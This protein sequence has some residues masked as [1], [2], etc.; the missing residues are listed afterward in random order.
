MQEEFNQ[1]DID[2]IKSKI[3][4]SYFEL[5]KLYG[6]F[7]VGLILAYYYARGMPNMMKDITPAQFNII[8][9]VLFTFFITV[10]FI[11]LVRD[12]R[13]KVVPY[14]KEIAGGKKEVQRFHARK[15][16]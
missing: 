7:L 16:F 12:Y 11:F 3:D 5:A 13:K 9:T 8:Y 4:R 6:P 15:Y 10:F 1:A 14:K 2:L